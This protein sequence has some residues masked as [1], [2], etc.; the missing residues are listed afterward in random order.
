M[1]NGTPPTPVQQDVVTKEELEK[2]LLEGRSI[3]SS[4]IDTKFAEVTTLIKSGFPDN[5][6]RKHREVHE[7]LIQEAK[8]R[9][10]LWKSVREKTISGAVY[11]GLIFIALAIWEAIKS[12]VLK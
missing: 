11:S 10:E 5:D 9:R 1:T 6:P 2:K 4:H 12:G 8:D 7:A 3:M